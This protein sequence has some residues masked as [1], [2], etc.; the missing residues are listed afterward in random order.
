MGR[1]LDGRTRNVTISGFDDIV[2]DFTKF[3]DVKKRRMELLKVLDKPAT[4]LR[5]AIIKETP[6]YP[7][8]KN[9]TIKSRSKRTAFGMYYMQ[10][11][12]SSGTL[13]RSVK[14]FKAKKS[15]NPRVDVGHKVLKRPKNFKQW[16]KNAKKWDE[17]GWY[18]MFLLYGTG[19]SKF[20]G[21]GNQT[22][23]GGDD[24]L[25]TA[26]NK[27]KFKLNQSMKKYL[28]RYLNKKL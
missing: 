25:Q 26:Y 19:A 21:K 28:I 14:K 20:K 23:I 1:K 4:P 3:N 17:N 18:G 2:R 10:L 8:K 6:K 27:N 16:V 9:A 13:R 15:P 22:G 7:S 5:K 12:L 11:K 24:Y